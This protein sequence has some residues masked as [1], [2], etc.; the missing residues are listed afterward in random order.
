M[1]KLTGENTMV[2]NF[3]GWV[4]SSIVLM[5]SVGC[6]NTAPKR[7]VTPEVVESARA[8]TVLVLL[9]QREVEIDKPDVNGGGGLLGAIIE[10]IAESTMDKNRQKAIQP[11][12]DALIG[13]DFESRY[14][15]MLKQSLPSKLVREDAKYRIVRDVFELEKALVEVNGRNAVSVYARYAFEANF[16]YLYFDNVLRFGDI[17]MVLDGKGKPKVK[18]KS[19]EQMQGK[20]TFVFLQLRFFRIEKFGGY[21]AG[22]AA[23]SVRGWAPMKTHLP[24]R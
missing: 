4:L 18:Y 8:D 14:I 23:W 7:L 16:N 5:A 6:V 17:G 20:I 9:V 24:K 3:Y 21:E 12:R 2:R 19:E 11:I 15:E 1:F 13:L 10:G 22:A